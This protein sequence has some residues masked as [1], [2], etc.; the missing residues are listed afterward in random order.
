MKKRTEQ[1]ICDFFD[2][3]VELL[4]IKDSILKVCEI[5]T[6]V[7]EQGGKVLICGNGGSS[8]DA[9]HIVGELMKGFL[10]KRPIKKEMKQRF[11][12]QFGE[13]GKYIAER[14]QSGLP[15][16]SLNTQTAF[17]SAFSND[18]DPQLVYAQQVMGYSQKGDILIGIS[19]SGNAKNIVNAFM[20]AKTVGITCIGLTGK[21]GGKLSQIGDRC[22]IVPEQ[23]TYRIQEYHVLIY[24]LICAYIESEMFDE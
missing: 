19:T 14:L 4:A 7:Y 8:A 20:T 3:H 10:L 22:I 9:D 23:E 18:V 24:H 5:L 12:T 13:E 17:M 21:N 6:K 2:T 11:V 15:A 1:Q 16:I